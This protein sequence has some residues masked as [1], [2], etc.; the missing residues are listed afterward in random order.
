MPCARQRA[1]SRSIPS[2]AVDLVLSYGRTAYVRGAA[3]HVIGRNE[4]QR[5]KDLGVNVTRC[6]GIHV[7]RLDVVRAVRFDPLLAQIVHH[8]EQDVRLFDRSPVRSLDGKADACHR[9][10]DALPEK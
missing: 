5:A 3:V 7:G 4:V 1:A 2:D 8:D 10:E 6:Q 9:C